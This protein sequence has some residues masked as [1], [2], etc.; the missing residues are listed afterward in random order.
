MHEIRK[1]KYRSILA[2]KIS[3][4][5]IITDQFLSTPDYGNVLLKQLLLLLFYCNMFFL[6]QRGLSLE[7]NKNQ[8]STLE[9]KMLSKAGREVL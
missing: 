4:T 2:G 7:I 3:F 9:T 5:L 8:W 6:H 1:I